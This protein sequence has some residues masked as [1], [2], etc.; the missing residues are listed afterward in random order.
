MSITMVGAAIG[1][2]FSGSISDKIGRKKVILL[3]DLLFTAG[4]VIMAV[5]PTIPVLVTG[6]L[7]VGL[8]VGAAS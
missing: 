3:A 5:A 4:S 1:A 6:R 7:V 8:G 2:L